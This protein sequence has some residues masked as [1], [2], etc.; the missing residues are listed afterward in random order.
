MARKA[1]PKSETEARKPRAK[2]VGASDSDAPVKDYR[3][4]ESKRLNNPPA[5]LMG[6][7]S[8]AVAGQPETVYAGW[9]SFG[10]NQG[11]STV[12]A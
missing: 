2:R 12:L 7:K 4:E 10:G 6:Q 1:N 11:S 5:G 9:P 3:F 8:P